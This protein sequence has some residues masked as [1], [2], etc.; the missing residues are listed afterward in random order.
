MD[1]HL[2]RILAGETV[3]IQDQGHAVEEVPAADTELLDA[4]SRAVS[5]V[6]ERVGPAV[7]NIAVQVKSPRT[8]QE[9]EG[10]GSGVI[11]AP[12]GYILTNSHVVHSASKIR[13]VLLDG[14]TSDATLVGDDPATDLALIRASASGLPYAE[15]GD[16]TKLLPGQVVIAMGNPLGFQSTVSAGIVSALGRAMRSQ[17]G[18][19]IENI[20]QH[21][22]PL[23]PG[24][25]GGPLLN[26]RGRVVGINTAI[27]FQAQGIGFSIPA[28]TAILITSQLLQHGKIRRGYLGVAGQPRLLSRQLVRHYNLSNRYGVELIQV[29]QDTP[30]W[31]SGL[32]RGDIIVAIDDKAVQSIDEVHRILTA[33][34]GNEP[35]KLSYIRLTELLSTVVTPKIV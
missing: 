23:N 12:D 17:S 11:I 34:Q 29:E 28:E 30:A 7:V 6:V 14:S 18:R 13:I 9:Q 2:Q 16:S 3:E 24:N 35:L 8:Q 10:A 5:S 22:A 27:I 32:I 25:S 4:Y 19:L 15:L 1:S 21:T 31:E 20:I 26:T 33:Y